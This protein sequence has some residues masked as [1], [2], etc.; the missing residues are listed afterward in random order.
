MILLGLINKTFNFELFIVFMNKI[1][2]LVSFFISFILF[3]D[4]YTQNSFFE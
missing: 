4:T 1:Y 3:F 2:Y